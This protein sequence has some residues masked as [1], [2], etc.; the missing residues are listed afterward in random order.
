MTMC[1]STFEEEANLKKDYS[2]EGL[3]RGIFFMEGEIGERID[4]FR[5][6]GQ[7]VQLGENKEAIEQLSSVADE[8]VSIIKEDDSTFF[9]SFKD[10]IESGDYFRVESILN[11][12]TSMLHRA[13]LASSISGYY[14]QS[15]D[16]AQ[17]LETEGIIGKDG[18]VDFSQL[19][20]LVKSKMMGD[21][22]E[23]TSSRLMCC[24][25]FV[26]CWI[27]VAAIHGAAVAVYAAVES[28]VAVHAAVFFWTTA[29]T[30]GEGERI[31]AS[32]AYNLQKE[33][34]IDEI[35]TKFAYQ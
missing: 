12:S 23:S 8:V 2:G 26:A 7:K 34:M 29:Y 33:L 30:P 17:E 15:L 22:V 24:S 1:Q 5:K 35:T 16:I 4:L 6:L 11:E 28:V 3:F 31:L 27:Y 18:K 25:A 32:N 20:K 14:T 13:L 21:E 9:K 10:E 19:D